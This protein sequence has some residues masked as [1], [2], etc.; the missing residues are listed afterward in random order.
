MREAKASSLLSCRRRANPV[1][2]KPSNG[3]KINRATTLLEVMLA[4]S[5][6]AVAMCFL[7]KSMY[8]VS[9]SQYEI[10]KRQN[11][12]ADIEKIAEAVL[13]YTGTSVELFHEFDD[14]PEVYVRDWKTGGEP[15]ID[16]DMSKV[17]ITKSFESTVSSGKSIEVSTTLLRFDPN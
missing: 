6:L 12:F 16:T 13:L 8:G 15:T 2:E 3:V 11:T 9:A 4:I 14:P 7:L 10:Y 17:T 1:R 5:V